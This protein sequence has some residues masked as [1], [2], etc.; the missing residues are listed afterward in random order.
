MCAWC[1]LSQLR[2]VCTE[3]VCVVVP[4]CVA[5]IQL[6]NLFE[7]NLF[8]EMTLLHSFMLKGKCL[9]AFNYMISMH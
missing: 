6:R 8:E 3:L 5:I 4:C 2:L 7:R 1:V 9:K